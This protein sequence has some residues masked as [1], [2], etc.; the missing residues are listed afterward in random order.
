MLTYSKAA[1]ANKLPIGDKLVEILT[2]SRNLLEIASGDGQHAVHM[3][4]LLPDLIWQTS[5]LVENHDVISARLTAKAG[6]NVLM[7][8]QLDVAQ[9]IWPV[10]KV[11]A[12]YAANAV[13]IMSWTHVEAMFAGIGRVLEDG[14]LLMLYG[15]Y[16]YGG[17]FTT[18]SN[19]QFDLWLKSRDPVSGIRDFEAVD[20]LAQGIGLVL[21]AD[22]AMPSNNQLLVWRR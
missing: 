21:E 19:G 8:L 3:G 14:G 5:D 1:E 13:H 12:V 11:D 18:Q 9:E 7:P 4:S 6:K 22:H 17:G 10:D 16:K 2:S 15:A 20:Q